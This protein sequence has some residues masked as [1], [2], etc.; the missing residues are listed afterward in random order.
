MSTFIYLC[1]DIFFPLIRLVAPTPAI[2]KHVGG[3]CACSTTCW[4]Y[5]AIMHTSCSPLWTPAGTAT[6]NTGGVSSWS[7]WAKPSSPQPRQG[8]AVCPGDY[9]LPAWSYKPRPMVRRKRRR[10][11]RNRRHSQDPHERGS[12]VTC[13]RSANG[14]GTAAANVAHMHVKC[15]YQRSVLH[16]CS[17]VM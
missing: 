14:Y 7:R 12:S 8:G 10:R 1:D 9:L 13:A 3:P 2:S 15:I 6:R 17:C 16:A 4:T 5:L 11:R